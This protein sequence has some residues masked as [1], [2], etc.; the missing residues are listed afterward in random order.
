MLRQVIAGCVLVLATALPVAASDFVND[1]V[2]NYL[3]IQTALVNDDLAPVKA[4]ARAVQHHAT[5]LG[6]DGAPVAEA[7]ART[8][9]AT[10]LEAARAAFADLSTAIIGYAD[11]TKQPVAGK[12]VAFCPMANTSWVQADGAIANP[13]YGK[14]MASCGS[15][16]RK[17]DATR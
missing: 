8:A 2:G 7:A 10:S 14:A 6:A 15:S 3:T 13:Y 16:T 5:T 1:V 11:K 17:L 4:A 9:A 12:I